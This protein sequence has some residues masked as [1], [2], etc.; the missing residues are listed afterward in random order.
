MFLHLSK[1]HSKRRQINPNEFVNFQHWLNCQSKG[2]RSL[3][4]APFISFTLPLFFM[5]KFTL[6]LSVWRSSLSGEKQTLYLF[7]PLSPFILS[8]STS[9]QTFYF[10]FSPHLSLTWPAL[11]LEVDATQH[12]TSFSSHLITQTVSLSWTWPQTKIQLLKFI[13]NISN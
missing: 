10:C 5:K 8:F 4:L 9:L 13:S 11:S 7:L 6:S 12:L 1:T 3:L 2:L